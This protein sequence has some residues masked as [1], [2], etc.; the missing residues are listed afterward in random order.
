MNDL[1]AVAA[2]LNS[3]PRKDPG[4]ED[5]RGGPWAITYAQS[6]TAVLRRHREPKQCLSTLYAHGLAGGGIAPSTGS[7]GDSYANALAESVI[8][9]FKTE[10]I[11]H[12]GPWHHGEAVEC[13]ALAW[14]HWFNTRRMLEPIGY[15]PPAEYEAR[16]TE[17]A[18]MA[19]LTQL[20]PR[21]SRYGSNSPIRAPASS[22]PLRVP[23]PRFSVI[24]RA[25]LLLMPS[26]SRSPY[27]SPKRRTPTSVYVSERYRRH[28]LPVP[29]GTPVERW[30]DTPLKRHTARRP[31]ATSAANC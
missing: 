23:K 18:K 19:C 26:V 16:Y 5:T 11:Q 7:R 10:G 25:L 6:N 20:A 27:R 2:A 29:I 17:Q 13:V 21:Q 9:R 30:L 28:P 3:R 15:V 1:D 14:V 4:L 24:L 31:A 22:S 8:G 12:P